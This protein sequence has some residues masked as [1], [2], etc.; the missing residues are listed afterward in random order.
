MVQ[1]VASGLLGERV[2]K[3]CNVVRTEEIMYRKSCIG[4]YD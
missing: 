2:G 3:V 1:V 4:D